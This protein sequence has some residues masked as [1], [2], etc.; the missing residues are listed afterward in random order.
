V[1]AGLGALVRRQEEVQSAV[2][3]PQ[4]LIAVAYVIVFLAISAPNST[5]VT[6][7]SYVPFFTPTLMLVRLALGAVAWWEIGVTVGLMLATIYVL[8]VF[9]ARL[10]RYGVLMYG[11][12]PGLGQLVR[13]VRAG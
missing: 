10:Y 3:V 4:V 13:I 2:M 9:A 12:R 6:V 8:V 1:F 11:Q 7:L 5:W